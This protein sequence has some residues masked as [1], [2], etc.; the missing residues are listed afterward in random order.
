MTYKMKMS[1]ACIIQPKVKT[2]SEIVGREISTNP[3]KFNGIYA[4]ETKRNG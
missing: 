1:V 3:G 2:K 4:R